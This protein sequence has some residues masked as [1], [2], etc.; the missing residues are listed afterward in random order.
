MDPEIAALADALAN[1]LAGRPAHERLAAL[2]RA[3]AVPDQATPPHA[4]IACV[5]PAAP[6]DEAETR[7]PTS[8]DAGGI[9]VGLSL[10]PDAP[11]CDIRLDPPDG[12]DPAGEVAI[13]RRPG[14]F[15]VDL[16]DADGERIL[17]MSFPDGGAP[18]IRP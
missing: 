6:G 5:L 15:D 18:W 17:G 12:A 10:K 16:F 1:A 9:L 11:Y 14:G 4:R 13:T 8:E 7:V 2:A 3:G